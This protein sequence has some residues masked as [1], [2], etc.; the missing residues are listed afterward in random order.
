MAEEKTGEK[1]GTE[2]RVGRNAYL[3]LLGKKKGKKGKDRPLEVTHRSHKQ[4]KGMGFT[5][6]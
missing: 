6:L 1:K 5:A 3:F 2:K 4:K